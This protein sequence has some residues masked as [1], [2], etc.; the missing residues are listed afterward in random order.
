MP[1]ITM[2]PGTD[3]P[4][5][6]KCYRFTAKPCDYQSYFTKAPI[7]D[8]KCEYYWGE[9]AESVWNQLKEIVQIPDPTP[10]PIK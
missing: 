3:C 6:E 8:G 2:C 4:H 5:K 9:N 7:K 1:D 10:P